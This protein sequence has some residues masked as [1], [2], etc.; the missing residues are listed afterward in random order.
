MPKW[1]RA[2]AIARLA[3]LCPALI[4]IIE[5]MAESDLRQFYAAVRTTGAVRWLD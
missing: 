1:F 5:T 3:D 4:P 2:F